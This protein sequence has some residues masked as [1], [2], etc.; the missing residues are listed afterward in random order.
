MWNFGSIPEKNRYQS[1]VGKNVRV[2]ALKTCTHLRLDDKM[3]ANL[4]KLQ[5]GQT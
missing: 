2:N 4:V 1:L 5:Q 3:K